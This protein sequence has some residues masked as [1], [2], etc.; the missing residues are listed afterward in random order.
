MCK[1]TALALVGSL[2]QFKTNWLRTQL[3]I[4]GK[5]Q[6]TTTARIIEARITGY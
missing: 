5:P 6:K 1:G 2:S 3:S 4:E